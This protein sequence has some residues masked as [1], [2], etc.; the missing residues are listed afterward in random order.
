[1]M[2]RAAQEAG[3]TNAQINKQR[4][5]RWKAGRRGVDTPSTVTW[6]AKPATQSRALPPPLMVMPQQNMWLHMQK[7]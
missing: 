4:D 6:V 5:T 2:S 1:M 7:E 3:G